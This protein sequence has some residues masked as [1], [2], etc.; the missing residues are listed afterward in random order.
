MCSQFTYRVG[1]VFLTKGSSTTSDTLPSFN[2]SKHPCFPLRAT[3]F[4]NSPNSLSLALSL[5]PFLSKIPNPLSLLNS[6]I[7]NLRF[8]GFSWLYFGLTRVGGV[9]CD[10]SWHGIYLVGNG[11]SGFGIDFRLQKIAQQQY[12]LRQYWAIG[13]VCCSEHAQS[14]I[15]HKQP[16]MDLSITHLKLMWIYY[17]V[18]AQLRLLRMFGLR[19][20]RPEAI[21]RTFSYQFL[22]VLVPFININISC[23]GCLDPHLKCPF[24]P[25][26]THW[27]WLQMLCIWHICK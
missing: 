1:L 15:D 6:S 5:L 3:L 26:T 17:E 19:P 7:Y 2:P 24:V 25:W 14:Q 23:P 20:I 4:P 27:I 16:D 9:R 10:Y 11:G 8:V 22:W 12:S 13:E 18:W 21:H